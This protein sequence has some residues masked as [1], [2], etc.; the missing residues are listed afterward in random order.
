MEQDSDAELM[1]KTRMGD[2]QAFALLVD[3]HKDVLVNLLTRLTGTRDR[4]EDLAQEAFLRLYQ[5]ADRYIEQGKLLPYLYQIASN[6]V[7]TEER[8]RRRWR[9]LLPFVSYASASITPHQQE[10]GVLQTEAQAQVSAAIAQLP[11]VYRV[12]L[13]LHEIEGLAYEEIATICGVPE[14]TVKSRINRGRQRL[15]ERLAPYW[16]GVATC[17]TTST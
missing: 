11:L 12:P 3:R 8:R 15:R 13:V 4:A 1:V 2:Q 10:Y 9:L 17:Q 6:L 7:R 5:H 14:G 16:S